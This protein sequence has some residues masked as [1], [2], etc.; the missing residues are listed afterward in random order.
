MGRGC[1]RNRRVFKR[2]KYLCRQ[3]GAD[4]KRERERVRGDDDDDDGWMISNKQANISLQLDR[5]AHL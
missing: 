4:L 1:S 3:V 5:S 2:V